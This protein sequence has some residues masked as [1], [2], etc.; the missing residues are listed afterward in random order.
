MEIP[1]RILHL[2]ARIDQIYAELEGVGRDQS[3][4]FAASHMVGTIQSLL[5]VA[6]S[7]LIR[8]SGRI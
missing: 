2:A 8:L 3:V 5:R 4:S 7:Q 6:S 1:K